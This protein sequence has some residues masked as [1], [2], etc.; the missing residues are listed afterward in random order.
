MGMVD[1][2]HVTVKWEQTVV[3]HCRIQYFD[4]HLQSLTVEIVL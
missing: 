3:T 1:D 4:L 2:G